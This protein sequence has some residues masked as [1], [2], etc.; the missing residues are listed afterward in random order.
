MHRSSR[1]ALL[2]LAIVATIP[3]ASSASSEELLRDLGHDFATAFHDDWASSDSTLTHAFSLSDADRD[4]EATLAASVGGTE[5]RALIGTGSP[6]ATADA[7]LAMEPFVW[8]GSGLRIETTFDY[9]VEVRQSD[10]AR[11]D[12]PGMASWEWTDL[13]VA[14]WMSGDGLFGEGSGGSWAPEISATSTIV[15]NGQQRMRATGTATTGSSVRV[16]CTGTELTPTVSAWTFAELPYQS[17][18]NVQQASR[19]LRL[20]VQITS[21][22]IY[23]D[24]RLTCFDLATIEVR[25]N[26]FDPA[27]LTIDAGTAVHF[28]FTQAQNY[29]DI[30][31]EDDGWIYDGQEPRFFDR[32]GTYAYYCWI[33]G[34]SDGTGMAGTLTVI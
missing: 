29:H 4:G 32:P 13:G 15:V 20:D 3:T 2:A 30:Y 34:S 18:P 31:I 33:H 21:V 22:K 17:S 14:S 8:A 24:P 23:R 11:A 16:P 25:D 12:L 9:D 26:Y 28:D 5:A 10:L 6:Y 19:S 1:T 27:A 7:Y